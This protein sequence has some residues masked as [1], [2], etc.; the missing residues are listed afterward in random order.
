MFVTLMADSD[1]PS[2]MWTITLLLKQV[3]KQGPFHKFNCFIYQE[4]LEQQ[5][6]CWRYFG[7]NAHYLK[8]VIHSGLTTITRARV[9]NVLC[10]PTQCSPSPH[11]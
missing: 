5:N 11:Q 1:E 7:F 6:S 4:Y 8:G 2:D 10:L 3:L 9:T